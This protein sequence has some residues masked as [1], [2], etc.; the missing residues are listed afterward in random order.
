MKRIVGCCCF[1]S[2]FIPIIFILIILFG[3][4]PHYNSTQTAITNQYFHLQLGNIRSKI[5]QSMQLNPL[6]SLS[7]VDYEQDVCKNPYKYVCNHNEMNI[8]TMLLEN[9]KEVLKTAISKLSNNF[10]INCIKFHKQDIFIQREMVR[11]NPK[12]KTIYDFI[13]NNTNIEYIAAFL[14]KSGIRE[15]FHMGINLNNDL[16]FTQSERIIKN[17]NFVVEYLTH[18]NTPKNTPHHSKLY[19]NYKKIHD[20]VHF[21]FDITTYDY[22]IPR[23]IQQ[24]TGFQ[25]SYF[26]NDLDK[27]IVVNQD[28]LYHFHSLLNK[29]TLAEWRDYFVFAVYKSVL[30]QT[31]TLIPNDY[32]VCTKQMEQYF[33]LTVCRAFKREYNIKHINVKKFIDELFD[34]FK[35]IVL[36]DNMFDLIPDR[37]NKINESMQNIYINANKCALPSNNIS[38]TNFE[39]HYINAPMPYVN[40]IFDIIAN[41]DFQYRRFFIYDTFSRKLVENFINWGSSYNHKPSILTIPPTLLHFLTKYIVYDS[42]Q[43]HSMVDQVVYHEL[44]HFIDHEL[45]ENESVAYMNFR[46]LIR[47]VYKINTDDRVR[48]GENFADVIGFYVAYKS[49]NMKPRTNTEMKMFFTTY[50]RQWCGVDYLDYE[51]GSNMERAVLPLFTLKKEFN[52]I[53]NCT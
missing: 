39:T 27:T 19:E 14:F 37:I 22:G 40:T 6:F 12:M 53:F 4:I 23:V 25:L 13:Y 45:D 24:K 10:I 20:D 52:T 29:Y 2:W 32:R 8:Q 15:P 41:N 33:P 50:I 31:R 35:Q 49:W 1:V 47:T 46:R 38:L 9:N 42:T 16:F 17:N 43:W 48:D 34:K 36:V 21:T 44:G 11:T 18:H 26:L 7:V 5:K 30:H 28:L 3:S 51:H